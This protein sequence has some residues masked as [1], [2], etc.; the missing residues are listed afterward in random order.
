MG[1][2]ANI[3]GYAWRK[4]V[5]PGDP[6]SGKHNPKKTDIEPLGSALDVKF[7]DVD[8][9][10]SALVS[11]IQRKANIDVAVFTNVN[12]STGLEAGDVVNGV[13]LIAGMRV[14]LMAQSSGATITITS[15]PYTFT[16]SPTNGPRIVQASGAAPRSTDMDGPTEF[17]GAYFFSRDGTVGKGSKFVCLVTG[18][19]TVDTT[20][21]MFAL[22]EELDTSTPGAIDALRAGTTVASAASLDLSAATGDTIYI[23]DAAEAIEQITGL[24]ANVKRTLVALVDGLVIRASANILL[25][26]GYDLLLS[27][28]DA[29]TVVSKGGGVVQ[30]VLG[31]TGPQIVRPA[32]FDQPGIYV[33]PTDIVIDPKVFGDDDDVVHM[34]DRRIEPADLNDAGVYV[35]PTDI[36]IE[37]AADK[38]IAELIESGSGSGGGGGGW[39]PAY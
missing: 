19:V 9:R 28:N 15:G 7:D 12:I 37:T 2:F 35:D 3:V 1:Q 8:S 33:D 32:D 20:P 34:P 13:A 27:A 38:A 36:L 30:A 21:V 23:S 26:G 4:Y 22:D 6:S 18:D 10:I 16:N 24:S 17:R 14:C 5:N 39:G 25:R 11:G 31:E 29:L